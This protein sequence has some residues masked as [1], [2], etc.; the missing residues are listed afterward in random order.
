MNDKIDKIIGQLVT[1]AEGVGG[2]GGNNNKREIEK[3]KER[4]DDSRLVFVQCFRAR[5]LV[6]D[7]SE[8]VCGF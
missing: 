6:G 3:E 2:D 7:N 1:E 5:D 8:I 4:K